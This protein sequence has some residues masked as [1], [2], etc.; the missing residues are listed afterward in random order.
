[1]GVF[2]CPICLTPFPN[3]ELCTEHMESCKPI[4]KAKAPKK[5]VEPEGDN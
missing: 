2:Q 3:A 1:M 4:K 5:D